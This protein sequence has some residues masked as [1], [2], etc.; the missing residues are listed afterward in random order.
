[1]RSIKWLE[2]MRK[3]NT[4][5]LRVIGA[6]K[7]NGTGVAR[8]EAAAGTDAEGGARNERLAKRVIVEIDTETLA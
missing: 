3:V 7:T 2:N 4:K 5:A 1:M 8:S 6:K